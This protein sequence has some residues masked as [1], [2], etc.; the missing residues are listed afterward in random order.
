MSVEYKS[1]LLVLYSLCL[2][3]APASA[4]STDTK[5]P[6]CLTPKTSC[7]F[8]LF[9]HYEKTRHERTAFEIT[10]QE[11]KRPAV[12]HSLAFRKLPNGKEVTFEVVGNPSWNLGGNGKCISNAPRGREQEAHF[13]FTKVIGAADSLPARSVNLGEFQC[14]YDEGADS[15]VKMF[16]DKF[17]SIYDHPTVDSK[18]EGGTFPLARRIKIQEE[19]IKTLSEQIGAL[20]KRIQDLESARK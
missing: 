6:S 11:G 20:T 19:N 4:E 5:P 2:L 12:R 9:N 3:V 15:L 1:R 7:T 13:L 8:G 14:E 16:L 18:I 17:V 10:Y